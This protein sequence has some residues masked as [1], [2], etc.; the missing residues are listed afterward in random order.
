M[1]YF[2]GVATLVGSFGC[3]L[4]IAAYLQGGDL[5]HMLYAAVSGIVASITYV[6]FLFEELQ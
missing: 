2:L 5:D 6:F 1:R 4:Q 3:G